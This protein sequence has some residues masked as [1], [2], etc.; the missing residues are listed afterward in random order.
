MNI[1]AYAIII[2]D[3]IDMKKSA[4]EKALLKFKFVKKLFSIF[5]SII[6]AD[7]QTRT[8]VNCEEGSGTT[9]IPYPLIN[10]DKII[11]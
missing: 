10:T 6:G 3:I 9:P 2:M 1:I 8:G 7:N 5:L 11:I 4:F